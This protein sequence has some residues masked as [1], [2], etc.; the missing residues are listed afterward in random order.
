MITHSTDLTASNRKLLAALKRDGRASITTLAS[1]LGLSRATVQARM[2][3][4]IAGGIIQRFTIEV[5]SAVERDI[6]R[7][8]M[9]IELQGSMSR[10]VIAALRNIPEIAALH[11][12]N[13]NWDLIARIE[14]TSLA[15]FDRVLRRVREIKGILNSETN[16]LL[17]RA[18][19]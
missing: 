10:S 19:E 14:T 15:D 4:L 8:V 2:E 13:G 5:D 6:I 16:I 18:F 3:R 7:A 9:M 1:L 11:T 12:T 17:N